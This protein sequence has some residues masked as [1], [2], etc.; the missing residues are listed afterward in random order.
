MRRPKPSTNLPVE[1]LA[2]TELVKNRK[3]VGNNV[4]IHLEGRNLHVPLGYLHR[5]N[6]QVVLRQSFDLP[7]YGGSIFL[8]VLE[9][10][11]SEVDIIKEM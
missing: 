9:C 8:D 7:G 6:V 1:I 4:D 5:H 3:Q 11:S 2:S 10:W